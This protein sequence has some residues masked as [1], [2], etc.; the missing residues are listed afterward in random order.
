MSLRLILGERSVEWR[1]WAIGSWQSLKAF[2]IQPIPEGSGLLAGS[3][4]E[5]ENGSESGNV[6]VNTYTFEKYYSYCEVEKCHE[7]TEIDVGTI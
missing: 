1:R 2:D 7:Q 6:E 3:M 4:Q 5:S